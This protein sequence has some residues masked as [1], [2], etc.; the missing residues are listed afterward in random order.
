VITDGD[1][2]LF[3]PDRPAIWAFPPVNGAAEL[4]VAVNFSADPADVELPLDADWD[5][6]L[7]VLVSGDIAFQPLPGLELRP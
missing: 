4:L 6:R 7:I 5:G 2:E 3:L 1:F